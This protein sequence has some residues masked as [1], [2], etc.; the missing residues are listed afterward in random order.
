MNSFR[1]SNMDSSKNYSQ[2]FLHGFTTSILLESTSKVLSA[3]NPGIPARITL[4]IQS[5]RK[6]SFKTHFIC[7]SQDLFFLEIVPDNPSG[8][9]LKI[10][11]GNNPNFM[12]DL[13]EFLNLSSN[14]RFNHGCPSDSS[15]NDTNVAC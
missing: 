6:K 11:S 3:A 7:S 4:G 1:H 5:K 13:Q 9:A 2:A 15:K 8:I 14:Q 10:N 12:L